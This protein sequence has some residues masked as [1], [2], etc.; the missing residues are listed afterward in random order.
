MIFLKLIKVKA[1]YMHFSSFKYLLIN[2]KLLK[3]IS[4]KKFS[5]EILIKS[6]KVDFEIIQCK[7]LLI[8]LLL[9]LKL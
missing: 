5:S 8:E 6:V 7:I 2:K 4:L 1:Y 9:L 3:W